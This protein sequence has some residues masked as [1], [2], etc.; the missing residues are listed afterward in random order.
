MF[1]AMLWIIGENWKQPK[2]QIIGD[3]YINYDN[4]Y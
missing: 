4:S 3:D 1:I 2:Y